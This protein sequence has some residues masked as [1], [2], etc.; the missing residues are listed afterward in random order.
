MYENVKKM[1]IEN[2][3]LVALFRYE[4]RKFQDGGSLEILT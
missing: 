4:N 2:L 3:I 1:D